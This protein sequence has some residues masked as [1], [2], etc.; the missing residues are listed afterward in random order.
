MDERQKTIK[1]K[2]DS[3]VTANGFDEIAYKSE[4]LGYLPFGVYHWV[5]HQGKDFS[6]AFPAGWTLEDL[7]ILEQTGFLEKLKLTR[8][9]KTSLIGVLGIAFLLN[10]HRGWLIASRPSPCPAKSCDRATTH[11]NQGTQSIG[12]L[13][14]ERPY[15][16]IPSDFCQDGSS[17]NRPSS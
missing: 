9:R 7:A 14:D 15:R 2:I 10:A 11:S 4:W 3:V 1:G 8:I 6:S 17:E 13:N 5:E 12:A 16:P